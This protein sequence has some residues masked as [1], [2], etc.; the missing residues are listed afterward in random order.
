MS[1]SKGHSLQMVI[2]PEIICYEPGNLRPL[3]A[4]S[5][6][7][8]HATIH[9]GAFGQNKVVFPIEAISVNSGLWDFT[10]NLVTDRR[11]HSLKP[12]F[13]CL[14]VGKKTLSWFGYSVHSLAG[15]FSNRKGVI[16]VARIRSSCA[17]P[18]NFANNVKTFFFITFWD[19]SL[20]HIHMVE[21]PIF[22]LFFISRTCF[23]WNIVAVL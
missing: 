17:F 2:V 13:R 4:F 22:P 1:E 10:E 12:H 20:K 11:K 9:L 23:V 6:S 8:P 14:D 5:Q 21:S 15:K 18:Q 7:T 19:Q 3:A 16:F